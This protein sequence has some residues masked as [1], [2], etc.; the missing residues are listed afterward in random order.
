MQDNAPAWLK[1]P[2]D[3]NFPSPPVDTRAQ[4]L[5]FGELTWENFE[6][7]IQRLVRREAAIS[8]CWIYGVPGQTQ[9]GLDIL[10]TLHQTPKK[11]VC[12]QCKRVNNFSRKDIE[13]AVKKFLDGKWAK[14]ANRLV[15]CTSSA[16]NKTDQVDEIVKQRSILGEQGIEFQVWDGS[17]GGQL[18]ELLKCSSHDLT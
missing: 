17:D 5:P 15:L 6:R 18:S 4:S 12:Y 9:Y 1:A 14:K 11:Y 13:V 7:L 8:D 16:L 10:A 2:P 3:G